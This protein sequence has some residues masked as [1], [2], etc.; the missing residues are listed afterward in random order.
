MG[1]HVLCTEYKAC[2]ASSSRQRIL[3]FEYLC[4]ARA[5]LAVPWP[6]GVERTRRPSS[7]LGACGSSEQTVEVFSRFE[8]PGPRR[9]ASHSFPPFTVQLHMLIS[10]L[11]VADILV[12]RHS[13]PISDKVIS[14]HAQEH[15]SHEDA[16][17]PTYS[18]SRKYN[19]RDRCRYDCRKRPHKSPASATRLCVRSTRRV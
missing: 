18:Y 19:V 2:G 1:T 8:S 10:I 7:R 3:T 16:W 9:S 17:R 6:R 12:E 4:T 13:W 15:D 11:C 14:A 5:H